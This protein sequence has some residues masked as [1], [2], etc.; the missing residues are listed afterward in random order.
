MDL[1]Y[2]SKVILWE[3][4]PRQKTGHSGSSSSSTAAVAGRTNPG[5]GALASLFLLT[6]RMK[7]AL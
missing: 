4:E 3:T 1:R 7:R 5:L 2:V 6:Q